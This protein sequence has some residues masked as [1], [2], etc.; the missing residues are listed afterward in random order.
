MAR[1]TIEDLPE[2]DDVEGFG[3]SAGRAG[4]LTTMSYTAPVLPTFSLMPI[5]RPTPGGFNPVAGVR[6]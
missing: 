4:G 1:I 5:P 2:E 3:F 6:G